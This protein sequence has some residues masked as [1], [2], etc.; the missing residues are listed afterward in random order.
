[1]TVDAA[2]GITTGISAPIART[3]SQVLVNP[4]SKKEDLKQPG[5]IFPLIAKNGGV[6]RRAGHTEAAV[7]LATL[8]GSSARRRD[9]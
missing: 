6:L 9:L 3:P 2:V 1:M 7:D 4:A 8:A 5:H